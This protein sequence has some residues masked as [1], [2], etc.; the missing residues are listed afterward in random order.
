[1]KHFTHKKLESKAPYHYTMCGLDDVYL[2][3]GYDRKETLYGNGVVIH[4]QDDLHRAIGLHL[5]NE[6]KALSPKEVRFLR[7]EMN[8]T[9]SQLGDVLGVTD[10]S[11][12]RWEKGETTIPGPA[13]L[14]IRVVYL[15]HLS[16]KIDV[17]QLSRQLREKDAPADNKQFFAQTEEGWQLAA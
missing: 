7:H 16:E 8:L 5:A 9:Q 10:Q 14:L 3:S 4:D 2:T 12:A 11:V 15:G 17:V 13:D 6:K 1:M